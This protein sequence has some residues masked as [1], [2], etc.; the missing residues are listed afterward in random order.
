MLVLDNSILFNVCSHKT[1][2]F[3]MNSILNIML[4]PKK[5][6]TLYFFIAVILSVNSL[7]C[8]GQ[9]SK[10]VTL[11]P[12][13]QNEIVQNYVSALDSFAQAMPIVG[14]D[15]ESIWAADTVHIM[16]QRVKNGRNSF[17]RN[18]ADIYQMQ[19]F[20]GYGMAYFNA[21]VGA[22]NDSSG[23]CNYTLHRIL[24]VGDSL[25]RGVIADGFK[26]MN[27]WNHLQ[28]ESILNMSLFHKLSLMNFYPQNEDNDF[29]YCAWNVI[30]MD[31]INKNRIFTD[32]EMFQVASIIESV[33][34][35]KMIVPLITMLDGT[36]GLAEKKKDYV[37]EVALY[38]D[39]KS[40]PVYACLYDGKKPK[41]LGDKEFE[42]YML[43]S[44]RYKTELLR[45]ATQEMLAIKANSSSESK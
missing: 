14:N 37:V 42:A 36:S 45:I 43:K 29:A 32:K 12:S 31:S 2:S 22:A 5:R 16:A 25:H 6:R 28:F 13:A 24:A 3:S 33:S 11:S 44:T 17:L 39:S 18:M 26:N 27:K 8:S 41:L 19:N 20:I 1:I 30:V 34:F 21:I 10:W 7:V 40:M 35:F 38:F 23:L 9:N 15:S 4:F